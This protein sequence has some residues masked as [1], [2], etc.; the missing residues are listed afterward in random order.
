MRSHRGRRHL[1]LCPMKLARKKRSLWAWMLFFSVL[2]SALHC[3]SGTGPMT[4]MQLGG[5]A[6]AHAGHH[7]HAGHGEAGTAHIHSS[8]DT[9]CEFASPFSAII[10]AAFFG[11]LGVLALETGR[12]LPAWCIAR[13]PRCRWPPANP[14]ASP[15]LLPVL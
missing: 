3:A 12:S 7:Q 15:I 13:Q 1:E 8:A 11:L 2:A 6:D 5:G 4:R 9:G 14:R 10:L